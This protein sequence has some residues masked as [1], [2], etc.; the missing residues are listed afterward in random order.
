MSSTVPDRPVGGLAI[1][2]QDLAAAVQACR[3]WADVSRSALDIGD[4]RI[5]IRM[6]S[7]AHAEV[8][9]D[10]G[11]QEFM[12]DLTYYWDEDL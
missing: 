7:G 1:S 10:A 6:P 9:Y 11:R 5:P 2:C 3:E 8:L 4:V 12:V